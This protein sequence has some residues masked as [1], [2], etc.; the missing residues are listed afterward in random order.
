VGL[1]YL[2]NPRVATRIFRS[3]AAFITPEDRR[4]NILNRTA[5][6]IWDLCGQ[7]PMTVEALC[8]VMEARYAGDPAAIRRDVEE[9]L[10]GLVAMGALLRREQAV[11]ATGP[12]P[13]DTPGAPPRSEPK[14][15]GS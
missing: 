9:L 11:G 12:Q 4:I 8:A 15:E 13:S 5:T 3:E 6:E 7:Q 2:Q 10:E 1:V 14:S